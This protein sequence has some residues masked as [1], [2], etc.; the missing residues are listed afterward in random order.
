MHFL[1]TACKQ[2]EGEKQ[3][4]EPEPAALLK[5]TRFVFTDVQRRTLKAIFKE[6]SRPSKD[7]QIAIAKELNLEVNT[8]SNFFMNARRRS[9]DKWLDDSGNNNRISGDEMSGSPGSCHSMDSADSLSQHGGGGVQ[10]D[11]TTEMLDAA[12]IKTEDEANAT[13]YVPTITHV[14][15]ADLQMLNSPDIQVTGHTFMSNAVDDLTP[16]YVKAENDI[17]TELYM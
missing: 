4:R 10:L 14:T 16:T 15:S 17:K 6:N 3:Q 2:K 8:V 12:F 13:S 11:S 7:M 9:R 1:F 5:K